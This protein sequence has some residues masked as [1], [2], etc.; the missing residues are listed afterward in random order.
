MNIQ[1]S[2]FTKQGKLPMFARPEVTR[3]FVYI[4][5]VIA[6]FAD[7][8]LHMCP[9]IAGE[10]FNIGTG[11]QTSLS[12]LANLTKQLF[13]IQDEPQFSP[14]AGRAWDVD[15]W[16]AN[17]EKAREVLGWTAKIM[18]DDGLVYTLDWWKN[19]LGNACT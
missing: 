19:Y 12:S 2:F 14:G 3:D 7:A 1:R 8:A 10:S 6:A 9:E 16:H 15:H 4:D 17:S 13:N 11:I 18:L 5:D